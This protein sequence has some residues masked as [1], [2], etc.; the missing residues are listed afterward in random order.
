[1]RLKERYKIDHPQP[2]AGRG[3]IPE[4]FFLDKNF[5]SL[6]VFSS[7]FFQLS[8]QKYQRP[9]TLAFLERIGD[10]LKENFTEKSDSQFNPVRVNQVFIIISALD[11][12]DSNYKILIDLSKQMVLNPKNVCVLITKANLLS[13]KYIDEYDNI[14][15]EGHEKA[16]QVWKDKL[17][18]LGMDDYF[19]VDHKYSQE[20][21]E[22]ID[23]SEQCEM[24]TWDNFN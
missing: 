15:K 7:S 21:F 2:V 18:E 8:Q 16:L 19:F 23:L 6:P 11:E 12:L 5:I 13:S 22:R 4:S 3:K 20:L 17:K 1:M 10:A 24:R 14:D 9:K